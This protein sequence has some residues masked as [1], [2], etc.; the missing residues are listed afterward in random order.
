MPRC[1][2]CLRDSE[3]LTDEHVF[4]AA[5]GGD[6]VVRN[7]AC[8]ECNNGFS[9]FEQPLS[10]E[11]TPLRFLLRIPDR[12]GDVPEVKVKA[13]IGG[14]EK[15][16]KVLPDGKVQLKPVVTVKTLENGTTEILYQHMTDAQREKTRAE[17]KQKGFELIESR[18]DDAVEADISVAGNLEIVG[19][20]QGL[21]SAAKIAYTG[22]AYRMG[23]GFAMGESFNEVRGY[24][25]T[26]E[27]N[28]SARAF[29]N[30]HF[31]DACPQGPHQHSIVIAGRHDKARVDAIVRLF[32]ALCY[33][34]VLSDHY[35]GADFF[36][37]LVLDAHRGEINQ[38]LVANEQNE[39]LATEDV[40]TSKETI[41]DN[42]IAAGE[43]FVRFLE[44][45][46]QSYFV[47]LREGKA[48]AAA[49]PA[50]AAG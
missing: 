19:A 23:C 1:I 12:R 21:R 22:L 11:L 46:I 25:R 32:G 39:F 4:P 38:V 35:Q 47:R 3:K 16:A 36:D 13:T 43:Y 9:K 48:E 24:I 41:W 33:F 31:L 29:V 6:L 17:A 40:A 2:F 8:A 28:P 7:G 45:A 30:E 26:G 20:T 42:R 10:K 15:D 50:P 37:T 5:L 49:K 27:G 14:V 44:K 18:S 34:V